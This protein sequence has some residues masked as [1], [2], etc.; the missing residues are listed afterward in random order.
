[1]IN[2]NQRQV[3]GLTPR[4]STASAISRGNPVSAGGEDPSGPR[5]R[6]APE[7]IPALVSSRNNRIGTPFPPITCPGI[8]FVSSKRLNTWS[9]TT[10][11]HSRP[12]VLSHLSQNLGL[13]RQNASPSFG[14]HS[15]KGPYCEPAG[16][17]AATGETAC[18]TKATAQFRPAPACPRRARSGKT[19]QRPLS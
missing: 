8:G 18:P 10:A 19:P 2:P 6:A 4:K 11:A 13:F 1:M 14:S 7:R 15:G 12:S 16:V 9:L 3:N 17:A 5:M